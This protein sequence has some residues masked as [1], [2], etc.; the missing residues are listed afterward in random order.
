MSEAAT[1]LDAR[2]RRKRKLRISLTDRCNL[3]CLYCMPERP[4]WQPREALL[5][6]EEII[7]LVR[8][9]VTEL[10]MSEIR[11]TGG[12]P[13]L[14]RDVVEIVARLDELRPLG[15]ERIAMTS[16]GMR[17]PAMA[18]DLR[19]AGLDDLNISLDSIQPETVRRLTG[20]P[21]EPVLEG[22]EAARAAG[23]PV[24]LNA[25]VIRDYNEP[26]I[27]PV[28][29]WARSRRIP[30]R[31]I[32][33]MPL[34]GRGAWSAQRVMPETEILARLADHYSI[35]E[36][37]RTPDPAT[38]Y[39]LRPRD[40]RDATVQDYE[41]GI[42]STISRPFCASCDRVRLSPLGELY[43][44]LFSASGRD[45]RGPL[46]AGAS[47]AEL[48]SLIRGHIWHKEAGYVAQAGYVERPI[49]MH[50]LGG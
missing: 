50:H 12:E 2:G 5:R 11:L 1:L 24:K 18:A 38:L 35:R 47:D 14:R 30:L 40:A 33:F 25:V 27:L 23:I 6:Q 7:R 36:L 31:F 42:I 8:V 21:I 39:R 22:I 13:L 16:N 10:G 4:A 9:F 19:R 37:P 29:E 32:E 17:L 20:G 28:L 15:L 41:L 48:A 3:R 26:E 45:L 34:D 49:S 46:R 43:A 44:C